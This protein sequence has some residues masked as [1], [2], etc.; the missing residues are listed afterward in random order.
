MEAGPH[1]EVQQFACLSKS[2]LRIILQASKDPSWFQKGQVSPNAACLMRG[3]CFGT[4]GL[5]FQ[6]LVMSHDSF[7]LILL[8]LTE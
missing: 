3:L 2:I 1:L 8:K 7:G 6:D 5:L 4:N